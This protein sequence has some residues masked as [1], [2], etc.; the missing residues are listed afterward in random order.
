MS[1]NGEISDPDSSSPESSINLDPAIAASVHPG[2]EPAVHKCKEHIRRPGIHAAQ[3]PSVIWGPSCRLRPPLQLVPAQR[4]AGASLYNWSAPVQ[5]ERT[6]VRIYELCARHSH[7]AGVGYTMPIS[8]DS[9]R[10]IRRGSG[11]AV[12]E[13]DDS[14]AYDLEEDDYGL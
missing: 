11:V 9:M 14:D 3:D 12:S 1:S 2:L 13:D 4:V 5:L 8:S 10:G 7:A 6:N